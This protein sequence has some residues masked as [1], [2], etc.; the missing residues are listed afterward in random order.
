MFDTIQLIPASQ[1]DVA[2]FPNIQAETGSPYFEMLF[3]DD[4]HNNIQRVSPIIVLTIWKL[5]PRIWDS[6]DPP[7][8]LITKN[9]GT[10]GL[11]GTI[12]RVWV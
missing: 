2:H 7:V 8:D 6:L 11:E 5:M 3:F 4:E 1:K 12:S 9:C 10:H